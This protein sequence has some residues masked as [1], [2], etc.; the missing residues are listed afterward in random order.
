MHLHSVCASAIA[1]PGVK[2]VRFLVGALFAGAT[3]VVSMGSSLAA[4]PLGQVTPFGA[5]Q[6]MLQGQPQGQTQTAPTFAVSGSLFGGYDFDQPAQSQGFA[7]GG[8]QFGGNVGFALS[9]RGQ[10]LGFAASGG[11]AFHLFEME[12]EVKPQWSHNA[13]AAVSAQLTRRLGFQASGSAG[14]SP[15]YQFMMFSPLGAVT[16]GHV[17]P[18]TSNYHLS[19]HDVFM[20]QAGT[21]LNYAPTTRSSFSADYGI[22][23]VD[24][25]DD[26]LDLTTHNI[27]GTYRRSMTRNA[28]LHAGYGYHQGG[29]RTI[30]ATGTAPVFHAHN[31]DL[32][33][34]YARALS[35]SRRTSLSFGFGS[36]LVGYGSGNSFRFFGHAM[37]NRE[38]GRSWR[39]NLGYSR[40]TRFVN[41]L[42]DPLFADTLG[43]NLAGRMS[44]LG[45]T[46]AA[47]YATGQVGLSSGSF[48]SHQGTVRLQAGIGGAAALFGEYF[49]YHYL[50]DRD[51]LP[52]GSPRGLNRQGVRAGV[53]VAVPLVR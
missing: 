26:A 22:G 47:N 13:A 42:L 11:S 7:G 52:G 1:G 34:D 4:Q 24:F 37:L 38:L 3:A 36:G 6:Q 50:F 21:S 16:P 18:P 8:Q 43:V 12:D 5:G 44:R 9:T 29:G 45:L 32:G 19:T 30:Q 49:Y 46:A 14:Y 17:L 53:N 35:I 31:I 15:Q 33:V 23:Y 25:G 41:G 2:T 48:S 10:R 20:Y 40:D 27:A 28:V 51:V 39:A